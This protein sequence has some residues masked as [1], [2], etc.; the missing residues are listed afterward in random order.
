[1]AAL[2]VCDPGL[3]PGP[4]LEARAVVI[5]VAPGRTQDR[6]ALYVN[7]TRRVLER[8]AEAPLQRVVWI[9]STSALPARDAWLDERCTERPGEERGQV[10]RDAEQVVAEVAEARGVPWW[11]L[12]LG[13]IYGP[14]RELS[15]IYRRR[16]AEPLPGNG[17]APTNLVHRDD[18]VAAVVAALSAPPHASGI[19][20]VVDDDHVPRRVMYA[21]I[22]D[23]EG[24]EPLAW[25]EPAPRGAVP[26]GKRV[27]NLRLKHELGVRLRH[28][29]HHLGQ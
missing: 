3:D 14:E 15:R 8:L 20:H 22:A 29:T 11:V 9:G 28:P 13:G 4:L 12:R 16:G 18:A 17:M 19:V 10:Q 26:R 24:W 6:R 5:C 1:M 21:R 27:S 7:G 2:D 25:A 23:R